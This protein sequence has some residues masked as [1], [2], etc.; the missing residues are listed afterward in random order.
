M[1]ATP[2]TI[3]IPVESQVR[4]LDA[5]ILLA[6]A[7]AE[8]GFPVV[9]GSRAF[10]HFQVEK[11]PRGVYLAKSMRTLS[12]RMFTILRQLGHEIVAWDEEGLVR[13]PDQEY[14]R[15]RLS[16]VTMGMISHLLTWGEDDARVLRNYT[17]YA[18]TPIHPVG[19]P[20]IDLLRPELRTYYR[21]KSAALHKRFGD[22]VLIN[23]NFSKV[24]HF[25]SHLS[26]L[27]KPALAL[28]AGG[29]ETFDAGKGRLKQVLFER[30][31]EMLPALCRLL[32]E[33]TIVVRPHPAENHDPWLAI[34]RQHTNLA[35]I[36]EDSVTPWLMAAKVLIANG[37]TTMIE[38][39]VLGT[40]TVAYQPVL[41]GVYDDE[42]PNEVSHRAFSLA[43]L[44]EHVSNV[45]AGTKGSLTYERRREIMDRHIT[46][47]DG[48]LAIDRMVD[49]LVAG[50]YLQHQPP[51][52]LLTKYLQ[53]CLHNKVRTVSK[54]I[55]MRRPGHR[56]NL[57]YH[58]HRFPGITV[59][60]LQGRVSRLGKLVNRFHQVQVKQL[61][62]YIFTMNSKG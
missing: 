56:N 26:E 28:A 8:K 60:E 12:E 47:L 39:A 51:P 37:C 41:G 40:P 46:A 6:C 59:A 36:N 62:P 31:Q 44:C 20:R 55:N 45:M 34:A 42:L 35:V 49:V 48:P 32:P 13:W 52:T 27:K 3:I 14:Y 2:S 15:W 38:A 58:Q 5:K 17:G 43:E 4:E 50:G 29:E 57:S 7:A 61:A 1:S 19:N 10:L 23:T 16:P 25:F 24:N 30:F 9:I 21:E 22:F 53:G 54:K 11:I 18:G 33:H